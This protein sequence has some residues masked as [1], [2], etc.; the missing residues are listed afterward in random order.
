MLINAN[1]NRPKMIFRK[2]NA[3]FKGPK[4]IFFGGKLRENF[5]RKAQLL[6]FTFVMAH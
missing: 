1:N 6:Q 3:H 5:L 2:C 4:W